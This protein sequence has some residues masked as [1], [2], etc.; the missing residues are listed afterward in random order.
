MGLS[1]TTLKSI[2]SDTLKNT[3]I[4]IKN[5]C[6]SKDTIKRVKRQPTELEKLYLIRVQ[7]P[8]YEKNIYNSTTDN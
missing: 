1:G 6:V 3:E 7:Y 5:V 2:I 8:E 4:K